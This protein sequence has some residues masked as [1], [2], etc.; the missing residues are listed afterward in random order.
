MQLAHLAGREAPLAV[1]QDG[2]V[3]QDLRAPRAAVIG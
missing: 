3:A 1:V 2:R